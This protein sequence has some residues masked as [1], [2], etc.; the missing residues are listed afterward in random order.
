MSH[1]G[2]RQLAQLI[3]HQRQELAGGVRVAFGDGAQDPSDL[4]QEA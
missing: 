3:V 1:L 4:A 2:R